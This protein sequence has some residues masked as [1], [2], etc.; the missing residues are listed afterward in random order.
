MKTKQFRLGFIALSLL[1]FCAACSLPGVSD[2]GNDTKFP[3]PFNFFETFA[4]RASETPTATATRTPYPTPTA[5]D[6]PAPYF[7]TPGP[8]QITPVPNPA[9]VIH[10]PD[11]FT[12]LLL[13]SDRRKSTF[14]T[15]VMVLVN[16]QPDYNTI[17][18]ISIQR[19]FFAYIPGWKMNRLN[20]AFQ[21]G[22]FGYYPGLGPALIKDTLLYNLGVEIDRYILVDF[23]GFEEIVDTL[24]GVD[25]PV[26]CAYTDWRLKDPGLDPEDEDNWHLFTVPSGVVHM[27]GEYALWYAR[28]RSKSS[29]FD[30]NKRQQDML[31]ALFGQALR[32]EL[33]SNLPVLYGQLSESVITDFTLVDALNLGPFISTLKSAQ[34]RSYYI[35]RDVLTR[36][37]T[38]R[39]REVQIPNKLALYALMADA[40]GPPSETEQLHTS[41]QVE[42]WNGT[43]QLSWDV[44]AAER[45]NFAGFDSV[46]NPPDNTNY[47]QTTLYDFTSG[48]DSEPAQTLGQLFNI[49][50]NLIT[51]VPSEDSPMDYL[52]ILGADFDPCFSPKDIQ[53]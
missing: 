33:I 11:D 51:L 41:L 42:I 2:N 3:T 24:G 26:A 49:D 37:K 27:D 34:I 7:G 8:T 45:L 5:H 39:G 36:W 29:D 16:I 30:R 31:R 1:I 14:A 50:P 35:D 23:A 52:L 21:H 46:I 22:E 40:M 9:P 6:W 12:I 44:L 17:N 18:L 28:A 4:P 43:S 15:D 32:L 47:A 38:P 10:N 48:A 19:D 53:R 20:G 25:L 13:G